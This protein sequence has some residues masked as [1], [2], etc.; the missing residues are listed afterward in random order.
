MPAISLG[1]GDVIEQQCSRVLSRLGI[2]PTAV[3]D[4][5]FFVDAGRQRKVIEGL[6][7]KP[8]S[9]FIRD[10]QQEIEVVVIVSVQSLNI[11][12]CPYLHEVALLKCQTGRQQL[13]FPLEVSAVGSFQPL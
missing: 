13:R 8:T 1:G 12:K 6:I 4:L 7:G 5:I 9:L 3:L 11:Q 10:F 2:K